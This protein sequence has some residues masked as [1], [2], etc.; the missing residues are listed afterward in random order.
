MKKL[1]A[2]LLALLIAGAFTA[3]AE[4]DLLA[5]IQAR[6]TLVI[7]T[8]GNWPP[9]TYHDEGDA[10][11]GLDVEI[12]TLIANGLG[13]APDFQETVWDAILAGVD[14][15]RFDI[16]CNGVGYTEERAE[17][18]SFSTPYVYTPKVLV[19]RGDNDDI[20]TLEDLAGRTTA[21]SPSSTYATLAEEYGAT[22]TY[23]N[24]LDE[25]IQL[26]EQGRVNATIN[27]RV[28]IEDYLAGHPDADIKI[29]QELPGDP[30]AFPM[31]KGEDAESLVAAVNGILDQA[32]Q[33]GTLAEISLRYFSEDRTQPE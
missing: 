30:V 29:V 4:D 31:R 12:G 19:V 21:N 25:T 20:H 5:R 8:E 32:R 18:Y 16:A 11:T 23:I 15:G 24:T 3:L 6:G 26:L 13:V 14:T 33:D 10:L 27:A 7:A 28:S 9:W 17:K 22:V 2:L 1:I